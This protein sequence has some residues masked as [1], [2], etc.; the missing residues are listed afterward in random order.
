M[1]I[2]YAAIPISR[3]TAFAHQSVCPS[4]CGSVRTS[5]F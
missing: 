4:V 5:R 1:D 3:I 2:Y